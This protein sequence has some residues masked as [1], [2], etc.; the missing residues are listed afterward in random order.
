MDYSKLEYFTL[1]FGMIFLGITVLLSLVRAILGP[2][3]TDRI[4]ATSVIGVQTIVMVCA[5]AF[6]LKEDFIVDVA[7]VYAA[8]SFLSVVVLVRLYVNWYLK[9]TKKNNEVKDGN[10]Q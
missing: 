10:V 9:R 8:I 4:L 7:I 2:R 3:F 6:L 5:T 1:Y